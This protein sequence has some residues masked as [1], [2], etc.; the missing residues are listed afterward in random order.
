MLRPV[1][2]FVLA[3][4][5]IQV[6]QLWEVIYMV[7]GGGPFNSST[8]LVYLIYQT[9]FI[10]GNYGKASAIGVVLMGI[11]MIFTLAQLKFWRETDV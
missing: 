4:Q 2:L 5:T 7:T 11:I 6:F 9:A 8:S 1:L 10:G 3:T